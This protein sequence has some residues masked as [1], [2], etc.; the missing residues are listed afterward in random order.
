MQGLKE[1]W[2]ASNSEYKRQNNLIKNNPE[3]LR[4]MHGAFQGFEMEKVIEDNESTVNNLKLM[5]QSS[6][7]VAQLVDDAIKLC[8]FT[9]THC[10]GILKGVINKDNADRFKFDTSA[11]TARANAVNQAMNDKALKKELV[12]QYID[13]MK[14]LGLDDKNILNLDDFMKNENLTAEQAKA[15]IDKY[16]KTLGYDSPNITIDGVRNNAL[17]TANTMVKDWTLMGVGVEAFRYPGE[18][19]RQWGDNQLKGIAEYTNRKMQERFTN[20]NAAYN[21]EAW[22]KLTS[23]REA[24]R[25]FG[26][27]LWNDSMD[28]THWGAVTVGIDYA[29]RNLED[30]TDINRKYDSG[31]L[32]D[33][34]TAAE[35]SAG[36]LAEQSA[37]VV[38]NA[39]EEGLFIGG[40]VAATEAGSVAVASGAIPSLATAGLQASAASGVTG[41]VSSVAGTVAGTVATAGVGIGAAVVTEAMVDGITAHSADALLG[42]DS[43][44]NTFSDAVG[45]VAMASIDNDVID[46]NNQISNN[47]ME[48]I[49]EQRIKEGLEP[50]PYDDTLIETPKLFDNIWGD[51]KDTWFGSSNTS[52]SDSTEVVNSVEVDESYAASNNT[53]ETETKGNFFT[54]LFGSKDSSKTNANYDPDYM[55]GKYNTGNIKEIVDNPS[56]GGREIH[57]RDGTVNFQPYDESKGI[58]PMFTITDDE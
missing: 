10:L 38:T 39:V 53:T 55:P 49:N 37:S 48:A 15:I 47:T 36:R 21:S 28:K 43:G 1:S 32:H 12:N 23:E 58:T 27:R 56:K 24:Q 54:D 34:Y 5:E 33:E 44:I 16:L 57:Y 19:L 18:Y 42:E 9:E 45:A 14:T 4:D 13:Y 3:E 41:A 25:D 52:V 29:A 8:G 26:K 50:I 22:G 6:D 40:V 17:T 20:P 31:L 11:Y 51:F 2:V 35:A 7:I 46:V 30:A